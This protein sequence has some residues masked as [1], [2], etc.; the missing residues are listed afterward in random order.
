MHTRA[1]RGA[2]SVSENSERAILDATSA[3]VSEA[4]RDN[5]ISPEDIVSIVFAVTKDLDAAFPAR[6]ARECGLTQVPLLDMVSPDVKG[7]MPGIVR[8]LLT[9]NTNMAQD[10][11]QH[12]YMGRAQALRPDLS[13]KPANREG[14]GS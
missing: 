12:V 14:V 9:F 5:R 13:R 4:L 6:A 2:T 11:V 10:S 7:S 1:V 3:M 8:M